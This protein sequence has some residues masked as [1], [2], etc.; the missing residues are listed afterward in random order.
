MRLLLSI[1]LSTLACFG[2]AA[3]EQPK[4][5][6]VAARLDALNASIKG[7]EEAETRASV[8]QA[9]A[10]MKA[11]ESAHT[12]AAAR[13]PEAQELAIQTRSFMALLNKQRAACGGEVDEQ[14][15]CIPKKEVKEEKPK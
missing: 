12:A 4:D 3:K 7:K 11:A 14:L 6:E 9:F 8:W 2:Q 10:Q 5:K 15:K 1:T 13:I